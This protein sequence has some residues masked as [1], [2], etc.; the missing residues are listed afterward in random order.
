MKPTSRATQPTAAGRRT[1]GALALYSENRVVFS[2]T[3]VL[4]PFRALT[5]PVIHDL[6]TVFL[7][8]GRADSENDQRY[9]ISGL[10]RNDHEPSVF[11]GSR[12]SDYRLF[13]LVVVAHF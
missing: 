12:K 2:D 1:G 9:E 7:I 11:D 5:T 3:N 13:S 6:R 10:E 4:A 8:V